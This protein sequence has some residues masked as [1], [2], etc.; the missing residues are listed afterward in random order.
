MGNSFY[1]NLGISIL[2]PTLY[3][4]KEA[5]LDS[6]QFFHEVSGYV[7]LLYDHLFDQDLISDNTAYNKNLKGAALITGAASLF[8]TRLIYGRKY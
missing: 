7:H 4:Y 2:P 1:I 5:H 3:E 6:F 8:K